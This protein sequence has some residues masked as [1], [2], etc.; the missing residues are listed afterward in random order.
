MDIAAIIR[1]ELVNDPCGIGYSNFPS[2]E[3]KLELLKSKYYGNFA[4]PAKKVPSDAT[5]KQVVEPRLYTILASEDETV[6][7][8]D[9]AENI[10]SDDIKEILEAK[11]EPP[12]E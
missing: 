8:D 4:K 3:K 2:M 9:I 12:K 6:K 7:V 1:D 10:T 11:I 5:V